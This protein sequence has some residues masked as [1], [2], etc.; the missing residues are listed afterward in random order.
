MDRALWNKKD[1]SPPQFQPLL[2][3]REIALS[4]WHQHCQV[5]GPVDVGCLTVICTRW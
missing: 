1:V 4:F 5:V 2:F 3:Q